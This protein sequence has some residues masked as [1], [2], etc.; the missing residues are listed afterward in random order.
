MTLASSHFNELS[1]PE[2][3]MQPTLKIIQNK[4]GADGAEMKLGGTVKK[5]IKKIKSKD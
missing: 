5:I 3:H 4:L 1:E 2:I